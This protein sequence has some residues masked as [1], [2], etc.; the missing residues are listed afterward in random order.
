MQDTNYSTLFFGKLPSFGDFIRYNAS[1]AEVRA[2][3]Q[4]IQ[5]G[6][7]MAS[8]YFDREW[9]SV[10]K[11]SPAYHFLFYPENTELFLTG[12]FHSS[13]D[14]S[15]RKYPF[16]I[17]RR[18][19][20]GLFD[21]KHNYLIPLVFTQFFNQSKQLIHDGLEGVP[22][23]EIIIRVDDLNENLQDFESCLNNF[24][25]YLKST[26]LEI[27]WSSLFGDFEDPKKFLLMKNLL[28]ILLPLLS[29]KSTSSSLGIRF[30][31]SHHTYLADKEVCFWIR[32]SM[33]ILGNAP[34]I[35]NIFWEIT[36]NGKQHYLFLFLRK[37]SVN[38][39]VQLM[40]PELENATICRL[41]EEGKEK[42]ADADQNI[43]SKYRSALETK[44]LTLGDF[45]CRL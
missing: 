6:L 4:W 31:L 35:P 30:P 44:E 20:K 32:V 36:K 26:T 9:D 33:Q 38:T 25:S 45:L 2:F 23:E 15:E 41:E 12:I 43:P 22:L 29:Q 18:T 40:Q 42:I 7:Y 3:E 34:I 8:K 5:E 21:E 10:Y 19:G 24:E 13:H 14:K 39:F 37:P 27:F 1:G 28:E 11:N 17:S 16:V